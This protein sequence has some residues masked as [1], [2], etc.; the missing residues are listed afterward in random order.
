MEVIHSRQEVHCGADRGTG[1]DYDRARYYSPTYGRFVSEDPLGLGN[2]SAELYPYAADDSVNG[3]DPT[4]LARVPPGGGGYPIQSFSG[5]RKDALAHNVGCTL[6]HLFS[7]FLP[8]L[9]SGG[10]GIGS[11]AIMIL[12]QGAVLELEG[13]SAIFV[14]IAGSGFLLLGAAIAGYGIYQTVHQCEAG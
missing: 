6:G 8:G 1:L 12:R 7:P 5:G 9:F 10:I 4:G 3:A 14:G 2:G 11:S 13:G